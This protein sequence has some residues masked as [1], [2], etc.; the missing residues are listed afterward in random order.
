[1]KPLCE[2]HATLTAQ[3]RARY[4]RQMILDGFG[5]DGQ[6]RLLNARVLVIGA[7]GLGS[8]S[9]LYL[10][11]A[12]VGTLGIID[13][14]AVDLSNLHRQVIHGTDL[15]GTPKTHSAAQRVQ[16]LNPDVTVIEHS[17]RLTDANA[18]R[19]IGSYDLVLDGTDNFY[20]RYLV[21]RVC[22]TLSVPEIWG[23]ILRWSAQ[24][25]VFWTGERASTFGADVCLRD[26][27]PTPPPPGTTPNCGEAG[28][29]GPLCGQVGSIMAAE[30]V[31]LITGI[32]EPLVGK[33]LV[34]DSLSGRYDTIPVTAH[35][36]R[37]APLGP[38]ALTEA[39]TMTLK[40]PSACAAFGGDPAETA[41]AENS[42][43]PIDIDIHQFAEAV[44]AG[45]TV[46]DVREN[47]E[48][49]I[50]AIKGTIHIP[51]GVLAGNPE[52]VAAQLPDG[53]VYVHCLSGG[54]SA[55]AVQVLRQFGV[56]AINVRGGIKA[57]WAEIDPKMPRY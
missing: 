10:A 43:A 18:E 48:V 49:A 19:L 31:K 7:G 1:M 8:P 46:L 28:V 39:C 12:G 15:L 9:L 3:Q 16:A 47:Y 45:A 11:A 13:D 5:D 4:A 30:A 17:E 24:V 21:D 14:D 52:A 6:K 20:T 44:A 40:N 38:D 34:I 50:S 22:S 55:Q 53:P 32:G 26:I 33:I 51:L 27:F 54:R 42:N 57:W 29:I 37:P 2:P 36:N 23:S 41:T 56:K 35:P 25:S